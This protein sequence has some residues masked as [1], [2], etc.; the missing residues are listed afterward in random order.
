MVQQFSE[1]GRAICQLCGK[2]FHV[3]TP[4]HLERKHDTTIKL[5]KE[6]FP[7]FPIVSKQFMAKQ[8]RS[9]STL[10]QEATKEKESEVEEVRETIRRNEDFIEE[11]DPESEPKIEPEIEPEITIPIEEDETKVPLVEEVD[12]G[13]EPLPTPKEEIEFVET[14]PQEKIDI[15]RYL[16][17]IFPHIRNNYSVVKKGL[18]GDTQY[19]LVTD[20]ADP[21]AKVIFSFPRSFWHNET[22][23]FDRLRERLA[24]DGWDVVVINSRNPLIRDVEKVVRTSDLLNKVEQ[25]TNYKEV[26]E[27]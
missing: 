16:K 3:I 7:E 21:V 13:E 8:Q 19:Q 27:S 12:F 14:S 25:N 10:F 9:R 2:A 1:D 26:K 15:V 11:G 23:D 17:G 22:L 4:K 18:H 6:Q 20:M 24:T 5:Y